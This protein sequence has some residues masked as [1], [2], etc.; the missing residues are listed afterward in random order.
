MKNTAKRPAKTQKKKSSGGKSGGIFDRI[1]KPLP[2]IATV[3]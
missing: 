3:G 1:K 2:V